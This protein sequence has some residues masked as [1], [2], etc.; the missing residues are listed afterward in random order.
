MPS[1]QDFYRGF[2]KVTFH[3][4][5]NVENLFLDFH[6]KEISRVNINGKLKAGGQVQFRDHR[7]TFKDDDAFHVNEVNE[8]NFEFENT[9]GEAGDGL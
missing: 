3:I 6:G 9:F 1:G 8:V 5:D 4:N 7:I 2:I